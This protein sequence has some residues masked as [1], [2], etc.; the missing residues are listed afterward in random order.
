MTAGMLFSQMTPPAGEVKRFERWYDQD[1]IPARMGLDGFV[2]AHRFWQVDPPR[3]TAPHHLAIYDLASLDALGTEDYRALKSAPGA[4]TEYFLSNV[5]TFT[6]FTTEQLSDQGDLSAHGPFL[7]VVAF[8]VP[9]GTN[10]TFADWYENEHAPLLLE[11]P[12][13]LRVHRYRVVDG[14]GGPWTHFALHELRSLEVMQSPER[15][16]ARRGPKR[17]LLA[18][19]SWFTDSGR[20]TYRRVATYS[21]QQ[22]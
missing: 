22:P 6:R 7:S 19:Q 18:G 16:R 20:W 9:D 11:A 17:D 4:E 8:A 1:H 10:D 2:G 5:L 3:D 14:Q 15:A 12:D 13:W 21:G